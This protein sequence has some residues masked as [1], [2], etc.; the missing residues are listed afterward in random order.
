MYDYIIHTVCRKYLLMNYP[1]TITIYNSNLLYINPI[2]I[3]QLSYA[4]YYI[5]HKFYPP[6]VKHVVLLY[7]HINKEAPYYLEMVV[8]TRVVKVERAVV[9]QYFTLNIQI[10]LA[11]KFM[12]FMP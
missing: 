11:I 3:A 1:I 6:F 10:F 2:I 8:A 7:L 9:S 12:Y 5:S 4:I